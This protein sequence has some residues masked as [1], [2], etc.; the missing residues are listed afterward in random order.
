MLLLLRKALFYLL[1]LLYCV[2]T[3]YV[4]LYALGYNFNP[5]EVELV[6]TGLVSIVT[7][8]KN[9]TITL[10]KKRVVEKSPTAVRGLLPGKYPLRISRKG[11][12][13]WEKE[14][15]IFPEKATRL[16]PVLLLPKKPEEEWLSSRA[17]QGLVPDFINSK[18]LAWEGD[19]LDGL[20]AF[21]PFFKRET[22]IGSEIRASSQMQILSTQAKKGSNLVLFKI[23]K[24]G[25]ESYVF[26]N[27]DH[28]KRRV[29]DLAGVIP[30]Q[31]ELLNWD[32][33]NPSAIYFLKDGL[34][35]GIDLHR[36]MLYPK[37][38]DVLGFGVKQNRLHLL[39]KDFS[40]IRT[41][42][43]L[44]NPEVLTEDSVLAKQ[45]F[46]PRAAQYYRIEIFQKDLL[47]K[48]LFVFLSDQGALIT[49]RLPYY[50]V[51]QGVLDF[52]YATQSDEEKILFWTR[53]ELGVIA[54][55]KIA[56][57]VFEKGPS[58]TWLYRQAADIRQ[59]FWAYDDTHV[60]FLDGD[61][62]YLVEA[63]GQE[64]YLLRPIAKVL[65][66]SSILYQER[67]HS[68]YYLSDGSQGGAPG[69]LIK[70]KL[71]D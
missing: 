25:A 23:R 54:F 22:P 24:A 49:N 1:V 67:N 69:R 38:N 15:E 46:S 39:K 43:R 5:E 11:Y 42:H 12:D 17:Y 70:R 7:E 44:A 51:D 29:R 66:G 14:I 71:V 61:Q 27:P 2:L 21:D 63:A 3:P 40:V 10:Q 62:I 37:T 32:P 45:I 28:D 55:V 64:P 30:A 31:S 20:W 68:V 59:A 60:V 53:R 56:E 16:E 41:D 6:K 19:S 48:D 4:I 65:A 33:K 8:P 47:K 9:A 26:L 35:S 50:H 52:R 57:G 58:Q 34:L 36:L 13:A 18:I